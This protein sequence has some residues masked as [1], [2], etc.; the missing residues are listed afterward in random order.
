M[1]PRLSKLELLAEIPAWILECDR[2]IRLAPDKL[3]HEGIVRG[4]HL[5]RRAVRNHD[6]FGQVINV[7]D[8]VE[9]LL[10]VVRNYDRGRAERVVELAHQ[11]T[12]HPERYGIQTGKRLVVHD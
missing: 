7:V 12:D 6:A 5:L 2:P 4:A 10:H 9:R 8:D 3:M 11:V 1:E